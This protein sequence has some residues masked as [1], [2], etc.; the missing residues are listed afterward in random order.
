MNDGKYSL[1]INK[2]DMP[3][4]ADTVFFSLKPQS[5]PIATV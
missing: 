4:L 1:G 5:S 2:H 3:G